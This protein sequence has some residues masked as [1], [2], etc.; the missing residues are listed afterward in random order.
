MRQFP[1]D[2]AAFGRERILVEP[3]RGARQ[4]WR[5][6][7]QL[8]TVSAN[9]TAPFAEFLT[10]TAPAFGRGMS[11]VAISPSDDVNWG[12]ALLNLSGRGLF[13]GAVLI[14]GESFG[15][16]GANH[17]IHGLLATA[18][19]SLRTVRQGQKFE[20]IRAEIGTEA[21]SGATPRSAFAVSRMGR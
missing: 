4:L 7:E 5:I 12:S 11:L 13:P 8:A 19:V 18:G 20:S 2:L 9:G 21:Y 14:D 15:G 3:Q 1:P 17:E 6:L 16:T 10:E